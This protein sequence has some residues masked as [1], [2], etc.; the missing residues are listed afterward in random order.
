MTARLDAANP[1]RPWWQRWRRGLLALLLLL[2]FTGSGLLW[3]QFGSDSDDAVRES[4]GTNQPE[5]NARMTPGRDRIFSEKK[6]NKPAPDAQIQGLKATGLPGEDALKTV[7]AATKPTSSTK[8][9]ATEND[10]SVTAAGPSREQSAA[11]PGT[12]GLE[13][14]SNSTTF[15]EP[16]R[17]KNARIASLENGSPGQ[18]N[19]SSIN[20]SSKLNRENKAYAN[21]QR[22][23]SL[24]RRRRSLANKNE[25]FGPF[26]RGSSDRVPG[27]SPPQTEL[28]APL[29]AEPD[30]RTSV[31]EVFSL[32]S[33]QFSAKNGLDGQFPVIA[34]VATPPAAPK[35]RRTE[36]TQRGRWGIRALLAP[37]FN[38]VSTL[39]PAA[40]GESF[41][42]LLEYEVI[43][44]WRVQAGAIRS[45]K[46]YNGTLADYNTAWRTKYYHVKPERV[47]GSCRILDLPVNLRFD[48]L[49]R[50]RYDV[51]VSAG[52]SSYLMR[53]EQYTYSYPPASWKAPDDRNFT[54]VNN[55]FAS[56]L[57]FSAGYQRQL[58][59]GFSLQVEPYL[60][61]PLSGVGAGGVRLYSTGLHL[62]LGF[63]AGR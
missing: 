32:K 44:R 37:D 16:G 11:T 41:G 26:L 35:I 28:N 17:A 36:P 58:G 25:S 39:K 50:P 56:T 49:R 22:I 47:D 1:P 59:K 29:P 55:H 15:G 54:R 4:V 14:N 12:E 3:W 60:K 8:Q 19:G 46:S 53:R 48:A 20:V 18:P 61:L 27:S 42:V 7:A 23:G 9:P 5:R 31:D 57:N 52:V 40:F 43:P 13:K 6:V 51:F 63:H 45:E 24:T 34:G 33:R 10:M 38:S 2:A 62:S 30:Q 21:P